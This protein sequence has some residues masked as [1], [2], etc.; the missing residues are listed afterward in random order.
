MMRIAI[1]DLAAAEALQVVL[2][3]EKIE[4]QVGI[5]GGVRTFD[6]HTPK[7]ELL[8]ELQRWALALMLAYHAVAATREIPTE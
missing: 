6:T 8:L 2:E 3:H 1:P 5:G 7:E 4:H